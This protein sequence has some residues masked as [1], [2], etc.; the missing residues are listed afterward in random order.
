MFHTRFSQFAAAA[1]TAAVLLGVFISGA[2]R[3][4]PAAPAR[5][6]EPPAGGKDAPASEVPRE[7]L[8]YGCKSFEEWR[9]RFLTELEPKARVE[10]VQA[11]ITFGVNGYGTEASETILALGRRQDE[12]AEENA[13]VRQAALGMVRLGRPALPALLD[14]LESRDAKCARLACEVLSAKV[15]KLRKEELRSEWPCLFE[16]GLTAETPRLLR[17]AT[18]Q[19]R[20]AAKLAAR[21][22]RRTDL[23]DDGVIPLVLNLLGDRE[24]EM[25]ELALD[26]LP[27]GA[28]QSSWPTVRPEPRLAVPA[29][30]RLLDDQ[31]SDV[32]VM[33]AARLEAYGAEAK[34]AGPALIQF[35]RD[36]EQEKKTFRRLYSASDARR[37]AADALTAIGPAAK[38][39]LLGQLEEN[40]D[41]RLREVLQKIE[42]NEAASPKE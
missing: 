6:E 16:K 14:G 1:A 30:V 13:E 33:A 40:E 12:E 38:L 19:N 22:I 7:K 10:C 39:L 17:L 24:V 5:A 9:M 26:F 36:I 29:L 32:C 18:G 42:E 35:L 28:G 15:E 2:L 11:L 37:R 31:D 25:R 21:L 41:E 20:D 4:R 23:K 27:D 3:L 34:D 8:R